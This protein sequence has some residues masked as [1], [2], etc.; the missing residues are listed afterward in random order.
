MSSGA[1]PEGAT[2]QGGTTCFQTTL[3]GGLARCAQRYGPF[4]PSCSGSFTRYK[5]Q[6][7]VLPEQVAVTW[8]SGRDHLS[9]ASS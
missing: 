1:A 9:V 4:C 2:L 8:Q 7:Q 5:R 3:Q 6:N